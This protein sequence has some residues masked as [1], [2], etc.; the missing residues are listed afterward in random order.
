[1]PATPAA[2]LAA[3]LRDGVVDDAEVVAWLRGG[4]ERWRAGKLPLHVALGLPASPAALAREERDRWLREAADCMPAEAKRWQR[5]RR[6]CEL[7]LRMGSKWDHLQDPPMTATA[8]EQCVFRARRAGAPM[9]LSARQLH[10]IIEA[11][12]ENASAELPSSR[13]A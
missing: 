12:P 9:T 2:L 8:T 3:R 6:L 4:L 7:I 5:A 11:N 1:M 10:T 13:A